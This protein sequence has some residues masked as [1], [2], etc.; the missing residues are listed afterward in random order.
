MSLSYPWLTTT[1]PDVC[2]LRAGDS[3]EKRNL[4]EPSRKES[5]YSI[6]IL[7]L[8]PLRLRCSENEAEQTLENA[9]IE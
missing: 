2:I 3:Q 1:Y 8:D 4:I 9:K 7:R 6:N 5:S